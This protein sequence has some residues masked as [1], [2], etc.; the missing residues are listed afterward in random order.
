MSNCR[1]VGRVLHN[2]HVPGSGPIWMDNVE[3]S[4]SCHDKL[5]Q[6]NHRGWGVSDCTHFEDVYIACNDA[7]TTTVEPTTAPTTTTTITDHSS[8]HSRKP[9]QHNTL[10]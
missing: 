9:Q 5:H 3:C 4:I 8:V 1:Y 6:C 10:A 2:V 7:T